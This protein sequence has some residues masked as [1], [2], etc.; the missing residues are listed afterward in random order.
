MVQMGKAKKEKGEK[1]RGKSASF[2]YLFC[3][4]KTKSDLAEQGRLK[5]PSFVRVAVGRL[6][7]TTIAI[8]FSPA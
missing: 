5:F 7:D 2:L 3:P 4:Q 8:C 1:E 6:A